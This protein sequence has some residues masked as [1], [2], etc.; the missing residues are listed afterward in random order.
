MRDPHGESWE[1]TL[2]QRNLRSHE[3][4]FSAEESVVTGWTLGLCLPSQ[5]MGAL[6]GAWG[7]TTNPA[8]PFLSLFPS[9][10]LIVSS[11]AIRHLQ[12]PEQDKPVINRGSPGFGEVPGTSPAWEGRHVTTVPGQV[13][14]RQALQISSLPRKYTQAA[15]P[16]V[17]CPA[18]LYVWVVRDVFCSPVELSGHH[19]KCRQ[20]EM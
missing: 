11:N 5:Q 20:T 13:G 15:G 4:L 7:P 10:A 14:Q 2:S 3:M 9:P 16:P 6:R 1:S 12:T 18:R 17:T 19:Y 8:P